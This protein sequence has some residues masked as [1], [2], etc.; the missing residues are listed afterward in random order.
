MN[1]PARTI[2]LQRQNGAFGFTLRHFIV[3]PPDVQDP[4]IVKKL[5]ACG[6]ANF[7]QP[8]DTVFVK[9]VIP[10]SEADVA[11]LKEGDRLIAVNGIPVSLQF[12]FADIVATI[13]KTPKTLVIQIVP[14][15]YDILQT[16]F[17]ETAHNPETNQRPVAAAVRSTNPEALYSSLMPVVSANSRS[18]YAGNG[19]PMAIV[20]PRVLQNIKQVQYSSDLT[21]QP[22]Q[23]QQGFKNQYT[24]PINSDVK[25]AI[26]SR[27]RHQIEQKEEF[28]KRPN[29]PLILEPTQQ[30]QQQ[31]RATLAFSQPNRLAPSTSSDYGRS[32]DSMRNQQSVSQELADIQNNRFAIREQF[33]KDRNSTNNA[34]FSLPTS[35]YYIQDG[36]Q[37][38]IG[39]SSSN[40]MTCESLRPVIGTS[41]IPSQGLRIVSERTKQFESGRP[42][43]PDGIDRTSLFRGELSRIN[44]KQVASNVALRRQVFEAKANIDSSW[45]CSSDDKIKDDKELKLLPA[46]AR[47]LS[48]ESVN[49]ENDKLHDVMSVAIKKER[50]KPVRENSYL[51][52]VRNSPEAVVLRQKVQQRA[53]SDD[54]ERK[55][56][57]TSYLKAT[58]NDEYHFTASDTDQNSI[59]ITPD[60]DDETQQQLKVN[61][62][63]TKALSYFRDNALSDVN[64]PITKQGI[65]HVKVTVINGRRSHDRNWRQCNAELKKN[66]LKLTIIREGKV[67]QSPDSSGGT[68]DLTNFD[69][70]DGNYTKRKNVFR[71]SSSHYPAACDSEC[72]LLLQTQS[73]QEMS[74]WMSCLRS[75]SKN[76]VKSDTECSSANV[77]AQKAEPQRVAAIETMQASTLS[78][79]DNPSPLPKTSA[80]QRKYHFG[81][82]SPSGQS[83]VTK[84]RKAPQNLLVSTSPLYKDGSDKETNSPKQKSWKHFVTNQF[85]K[86]Q[87]QTDSP[88]T[89]NEHANEG[90][91]LAQCTPSEENLYVPL[92]IAKCTNIVESKG[93]GIVGIYRI[94]GNTAAISN[95]NELI[96]RNGMDDEQTLNDP[97]WEDVNVVSSL[98]KLFI[99]SLSEPIVSNELYGNFIEADKKSDHVQ[100]FQ[101]LKSLLGK[102][103]QHNYETLKHLITHLCRVSENAPT[104]LMEPKNLA[105]IFGPSI[106]RKSNDSLEMVV[107]DMR[108][109]CQIVESLISNYGYFFENEPIP[110]PKNNNYQASNDSGN[111]LPSAD[112]LLENVAK[113]EPLSRDAHKETSSRFVANIVQAANRKI[114]KTAQRRSTSSS[115]TM[116]PDSLSLESMTTAESKDLQK[117][118]S[119]T[120]KLKSNESLAETPRSSEDEC[121]FIENGDNGSSSLTATVTE[122][123][124]NKLRSLRNSSVDSD[125]E[126]T[127]TKESSN[128]TTPTSTTITVTATTSNT[129]PRYSVISKMT[130]LQHPRP[131]TLGENIPFADESPE[132]PLIQARV[133]PIRQSINSNSSSGMDKQKSELH[134]EHSLKDKNC[135]KLSLDSSDTDSST[136]ESVN[137][138]RIRSV[139]RLEDSVLRKV[140][141]ILTN[142]EHLERKYSLNRS[143]SLNYKSHRSNNECCCAN[144]G[145]K[146]ARLSLTKDE[147]TDKNINKRRQLHDTTNTTSNLQQTTSGG[148]KYRRHSNGSNRSIRRRHT[149]GGVHDYP[150]IIKT[151][152]DRASFI[153]QIT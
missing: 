119:K 106:V 7:S 56:R 41:P 3:Y 53:A 82:R 25:E 38:M 149:V 55:T 73:Q 1:G 99:R 44:T 65:L 50:P 4:A 12:Q 30:Q 39:G 68:I 140:N 111:E 89:S 69:V 151:D 110:N 100:R 48:V 67:S 10:K 125:K 130:H 90:C 98:L 147:K 40:S 139:I 52:A 83:P 102:L 71:L 31:Q 75:V 72:E 103:P 33:F 142:L 118:N 42:L 21:P 109:Q 23:P 49:K 32:L 107:K 47:S 16:F 144:K 153:T 63:K 124:D 108:H 80:T 11:G 24:S 66:I 131:L 116:T 92:L 58:A 132:R 61:A 79:D 14:K 112:F 9:K 150:A 135:S 78:S 28:L 46:K 70:T 96:N 113:I 5:E 114:R 20:Q 84:S 128:A 2:V 62:S 6:L 101:E 88:P 37:S 97:K 120:A 148:S 93:M 18:V 94:P 59:S 86:M 74:D 129:N 43:S 146:S 87:P 35:P 26:L 57:R 51:T 121:A 17:S 126:E 95:L 13:Q 115:M 136:T 91:T 8:M 105:I 117:T 54:E 27:L 104:N 45:R 123:L 29:K 15:C 77:G 36:Q 60:G 34:Y 152:T 137:R 64:I 85:K 133:K 19:N 134:I 127:T 143:L 145:D 138:E 76:D 22:P 81:S 141:R 122:L